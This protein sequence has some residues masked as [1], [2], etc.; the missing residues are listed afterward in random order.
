[1]FRSDTVDGFGQLLSVACLDATTC[2]AVGTD[3]ANALIERWNG[4]SWSIVSSSTVGRL[5]DIECRT[6]ADCFA[7]GW[8]TTSTGAA[9]PL[10]ERWNGAAWAQ[11]TTPRPATDSSALTG[12]ACASATKCFADG[13]TSSGPWIDAW[14]GSIWSIDNANVAAAAA[15]SR[16][17]RARPRTIASPSV[18]R[19]RLRAR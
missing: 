8:F 12:V 11:V 14:D 18:H 13:W 15:V 19:H 4:S 2:F 16:G 17:L 5:E 1:M 6:A 7:V 10:I 9:C 3:R